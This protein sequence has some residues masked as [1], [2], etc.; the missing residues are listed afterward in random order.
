MTKAEKIEWIMS[1][2]DEL[3]LSRF[4]DL[5]R[6]YDNRDTMTPWEESLEYREYMELRGKLLRAEE[7]YESLREEFE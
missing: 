2:V 4:W 3:T 6:S 5:E 7:I 1:F